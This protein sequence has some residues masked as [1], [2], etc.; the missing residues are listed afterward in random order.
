MQVGVLLDVAAARWT[1]C[2]SELHSIRLTL[3]IVTAGQEIRFKCN[4]QLYQGGRKVATILAVQG[5][6]NKIKVVIAGFQ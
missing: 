2:L 6:I 3:K 4:G 5:A 1:Y